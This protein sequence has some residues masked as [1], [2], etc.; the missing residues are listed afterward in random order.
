MDHA[1]FLANKF[2]RMAGSPKPVQ[3]LQVLQRMKFRIGRRHGD[4]AAIIIKPWDGETLA[5]LDPP[6]AAIQVFDNPARID[7]RYVLQ[8]REEDNRYIEAFL[9]GYALLAMDD[10][11]TKV[12]FEEIPRPGENHDLVHKFARNLLVPGDALKEDLMLENGYSTIE[13]IAGTFK[14]SLCTLSDRL[15]ELKDLSPLH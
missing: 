2:W 9:T 1:V 4:A 3:A 6:A 12:R 7:C 10:K 13:S 5:K 14:V 11:A 15:K 8:E